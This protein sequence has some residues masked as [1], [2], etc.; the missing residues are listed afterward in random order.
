MKCRRSEELWS[1]YLDGTLPRPLTKDLEGHLAE[2]P[3]CPEFLEAFKEI[4]TAL[5]TMPHPHA[6]AQLVERLLAASRPRLA[7]LANLSN[8]AERARFAAPLVP[9]LSW[10]GWAAWGTAAALVAVLILG[11]S[12]AL[13]RLNQIGHRIYSVGL[14]A[15]RDTEGLIDELN[16]LRMTVG[17]AFEDRLDR[18]NQRLKDLE[19]ARRKNNGEPN[20]SNN[21]GGQRLSS[22]R[23]SKTSSQSRSDS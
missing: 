16:V 19:E 6:S 17:V 13:S 14:G 8:F 4:R 3:N 10:G 11:P 9:N 7:N 18:L 1:D 12:Q 15:Y 21:L 5:E 20:Q 22:Q 23:K 2:C